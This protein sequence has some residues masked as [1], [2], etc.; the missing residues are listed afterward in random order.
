VLNDGSGLSRGDMVTPEATLQLLTYMRRHRYATAFRD[1]LPIAGVDG[2]LRN[3]LKGT[4]AENNLRAKTGTLSSATSL[5]G[6]VTT[7]AGEELVFSIIVNNYPEDVDAVSVG[8]D[9]IAVLL[10]SFA[11]RS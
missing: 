6:Y 7:A 11:G 9:P 10:A 1:A 3:R 8:I 5:S 4:P 2:T